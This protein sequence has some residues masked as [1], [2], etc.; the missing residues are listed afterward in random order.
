MRIGTI[1][2]SI[3]LVLFPTIILADVTAVSVMNSDKTTVKIFY[4]GGKE[5]ARQILDKEGNIIETNAKI[6]DGVVKEYD[7]NGKLA[8]EWKFKSGRLEGL[9]KEFSLSGT[10]IAERNYRNNQREGVSKKYYKSGKLLAERNFKEDKLDGMTKM[11]YESGKVF[12]EL[13]YKAGK[14]D[15]TS[16]TYY[17][18]GT[19]GSEEIYK[20][21]QKIR[22]K[23]YDQQGK[24]LFDHDYTA[25]KSLNNTTTIQLNKGDKTEN[26]N[27]K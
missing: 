10:L 16:K 3:A 1:T 22:I 25:E 15:G 20:N 21:Q 7:E 5:I 6:P 24:L 13:N 12:A 8:F 2:L 11:Y 17:E 9:S 19:L 23:S 26:T 27:K 4:D 18:N 14:L